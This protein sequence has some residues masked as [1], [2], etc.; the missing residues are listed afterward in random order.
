MID[1]RSNK[2]Y[3]K[4][5]PFLEE[6]YKYGEKKIA[7]NI[8]I[9]YF[10]LG[11]FEEALKWYKIAKNNGFENEANNLIDQLNSSRKGSYNVN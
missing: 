10:V 3:K 5:L 9:S 7:L 11:D 8:G 2:E 1:N 6:Q 4:A